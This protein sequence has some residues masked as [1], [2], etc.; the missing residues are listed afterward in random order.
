M[1]VRPVVQGARPSL[2][3]SH[4]CCGSFCGASLLDGILEKISEVM[5]SNNSQNIKAKN[6]SEWSLLSRRNL[7]RGRL[8]DLPVRGY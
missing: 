3:R 5:S 1:L 2:G 7:L 6:E 4:G 8:P